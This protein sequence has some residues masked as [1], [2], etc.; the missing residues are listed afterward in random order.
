MSRIVG[1]VDDLTLS[2]GDL[3][4]RTG[5]DIPTLRRWE[6]YDG[7]LA[8][9]RTPGGQRRYGPADVDA[10]REVVQLVEQGWP[11]SSAAQVV[12]THRDTG[13]VVFDAT[14][15]DAF[16]A[17]VV[18]TNAEFEI[19]YVNPHLVELLGRDPSEVDTSRALE[20]LDEP[21]RNEVRQAFHDLRR[22]VTWSRTLRAKNL[23]G[24]EI[25][26]EAVAAPLMAPGGRIRGAVA[27]VH[28]LRPLR[29]AERSAAVRRHLLDSAGEVLVAVDVGQ[30]VVEWNSAAESAFERNAADARGRLLG[31]VLPGELGPPI[32]AAVRRAL[33]GEPS[34]FDL[35]GA[36]VDDGPVVEVQVRV[37]PIRPP[38]AERCTGASVAIVDITSSDASDTDTPSAY[39]SVL[40]TVSQS[41]LHGHP[42]E[43]ILQTTLD[44]VGRALA[45]EH[46]AFVEAD[47]RSGELRV[48]AAVGGQDLGP[49]PPRGPFGSHATF[50]VHAERPI[51]VPDFASE[52]RFDRGP[53]L[54]EVQAA[55]GLCAPVRW[56]RGQGA[57]S[58]YG[59][60]L[61]PLGPGEVSFVQ[62][63]ANLCALALAARNDG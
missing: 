25:E 3:A 4:R 54:G 37:R 22:G 1:V 14:L 11:P 24:E 16:P 62:S 42:V 29:A 35:R 57:L 31:E 9:T 15:L 13:A 53:M 51:I 38:A 48:L 28:D 63:A 46:A 55:C 5:V 26:L 32:L 21:S 18:I 40:A 8:P 33:E 34:T 6:R 27:V 41:L 60:E 45:M 20:T 7:L 61:R 23:A 49:L 58:A 47:T 52:R 36:R 10:V 12:A 2:I 39:T 19:L 50:A 30:L 59:V 17:G 44:G 56:R 43:Q